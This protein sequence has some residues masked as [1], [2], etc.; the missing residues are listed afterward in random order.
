MF[1][2]E[3]YMKKLKAFYELKMVIVFILV[4]SMFFSLTPFLGGYS[5]IY[6]KKTSPSPMWSMFRYNMRHTGRSPYDTTKTKNKLR[7]AFGTNSFVFSSPAIGSDGTIYV[8]SYDGYLYA[9]NPDGTLKWRYRT[10]G[11]IHS[12]PAIGSD[13]TIYVGSNDNY[14]YAVNPD[15]TLKW[16]YKTGGSVRSSPVIDPQGIVYVGSN[17]DYLYAIS[18]NGEFEWRYKTGGSIHSSPAIGSDGTIYVGSDDHY[19]YAIKPDGTLRWRFETGK[20]IRSSPAI[21]SDG[22][23]YVGSYD[24]YL[25]AVNPDGSLKWKCE[26]GKTIISSPAIG[27]DGTIYVGSNDYR[28]YAINPNG[29]LKWK[30]ETGDSIRSSPAISSD[31]TIYVGSYDNNLYAVGISPPTKPSNLSAT[32]TDT[33]IILKWSKSRGG[34]YPI[35]GYA[36][37]R[38]TSPGGEE[39]N[40]IA[41]VS[42]NVTT[43][44]DTNVQKGVLYYYYVKA[45]DNQNPPNYSDPSNEVFAALNL[46]I[47]AKTYGLGKIEP[48]GKVQVSYGKNKSFLIKANPDAFISKVLVDGKKIKVTN[49]SMMTYTFSNVASDHTIEAYFMQKQQSYPVTTTVASGFAKVVLSPSMSYVPEG[50]SVVVKIIPETGYHLNYIEDNGTMIPSYKLKQNPDGSYI[51][52]IQGMYS[53][54]KI[55]VYTDINR[56][57]VN[58]SYGKGGNVSPKGKVFA[59]NYG[60][61]FVLTITPEQ[62]YKVDKVTV[63]GREVKLSN[64][65]KLILNNVKEDCNIKITFKKV[66]SPSYYSSKVINLQINNPYIV[67]N[68]VKEKIDAQGSKPVIRN[69]R[70][71]LPVRSLIEALGGTIEWNPET[72]QVTIE[73]NGNTIILTIGKNIAL[74]NGIKTQIDPNNPNVVPIII[75]GRTYLPLRFIAEHLN[76][77]VEW[78]P[79]T[80]TITIYYFG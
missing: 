46:D 13:G 10:G 7:W 50:S 44:T 59:V 8:G 15:G 4:F 57:K 9:I 19:L 53:A 18:S 47:T 67:I 54:H 45:F 68:G 71:L 55:K 61:G 25:Y 73:L 2:K 34:T 31:G 29:T 80:K 23:I 66:T 42:A 74:V 28:L 40:P 41:T 36:I 20:K 16:R 3:A 79:S 37:Y 21:G 60:S 5:E 70:T 1:A 17:D 33:E 38:G 75:N 72:R 69:N 77:T 51:Y 32:P 11:L 14:L 65:N 62:G 63:N 6:A 58:V 52:T 22:T 26:P 27:S 39:S 64:G 48:S 76:C 78:S 24:H 56:Y 30:Y 43:Y 12:S 49:S 35:A